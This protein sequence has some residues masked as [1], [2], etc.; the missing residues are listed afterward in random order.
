MLQ[1]VFR[2]SSPERGFF[3]LRSG[4]GRARVRQGTTKWGLNRGRER[5]GKKCLLAV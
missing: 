4:R 2:V 3:V 1:G 5:E